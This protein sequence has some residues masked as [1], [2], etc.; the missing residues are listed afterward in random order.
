MLPLIKK[1]ILK[2]KML[3]Y[4]HLGKLIKFNNLSFGEV[5]LGTNASGNINELIE[6]I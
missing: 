6:I 4:I 1:F 3:F 5:H 2:T